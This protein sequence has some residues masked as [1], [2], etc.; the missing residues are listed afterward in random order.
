MFITTCFLVQACEFQRRPTHSLKRRL[1]IRTMQFTIGVNISEIYDSV[2]SEVVLSI[3]VHKVL[4]K[5]L[6]RFMF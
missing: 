5:F 6:I 4:C 1:R 2:D 3:L